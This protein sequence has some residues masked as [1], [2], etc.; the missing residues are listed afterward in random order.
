MYT[1]N[2]KMILSSCSVCPRNCGVDRMNGQKGFC[3]L[4]ASMNIA[5]ICVHKGEEPVIIGDTGICNIFFSG[6]NLRCIYCQNYEI[7]RPSSVSDNYTLESALDTIEGILSTGV[8]SVGFVS[9][10]HVIP[11]VMAI[12]RGMK[13]RGLKAV[14]IYNTNCFDKVETIRELDGLIDVFLPD[15]KYVSSEIS[16]DYSFA[17]EYCEVAIKAL[18]EMYRQK[19]S[20]LIIDDNGMITNGLIVRHLVL[21]G[22]V[23]ESIEVL[24][25]LADEL[26]PGVYLSLMSQYYPT[27]AVANHPMLLRPITVEEYEKVVEEMEHLGY[28]H[29]WRQEMDSSKTYR[30]DFSSDTP[31]SDR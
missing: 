26:S 25:M 9:P 2:E 20:T 4:D 3:G 16:R 7:S 31:F 6:C 23:D 29:G 14:T 11:Q 21:P 27:E 12:L 13:E 30:P 10:S 18:R 15:F 22:H 24:R 28:R 19:G 1:E 5:S 17:E 8:R